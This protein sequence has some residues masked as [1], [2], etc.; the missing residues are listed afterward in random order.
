MKI[1]WAK[2][3]I[4]VRNNELK[5]KTFAWVEARLG[6]NECSYILGRDESEKRGGRGEKKKER[7]K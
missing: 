3:N 4:D 6:S 7:K 5:Q 2:M 1:V